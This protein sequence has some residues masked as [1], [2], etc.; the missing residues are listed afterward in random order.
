MD[1]QSLWIRSVRPYPSLAVLADG[2]STFLKP[3]VPKR[4]SSWSQPS[5]TPG[6]LALCV[7]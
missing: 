3:I 5:T 2:A 6:T 7:P 1:S 4:L